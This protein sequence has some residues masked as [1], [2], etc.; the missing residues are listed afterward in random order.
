[1]A[2]NTSLPWVPMTGA[3]H[4]STACSSS[5]PQVITID[6]GS[7][8][9]GRP[10]SSSRYDDRRAVPDRW[11]LNS[12]RSPSGAPMHH[13]GGVTPPP[14][15][16]MR[17]GS[18]SSSSS[19][20]PSHLSPGLP[21]MHKVDPGPPPPLT[22]LQAGVNRHPAPNSGALGVGGVS[23]KPYDFARRNAVSPRSS[24]P[25]AAAPAGAPLGAPVPYPT[26]YSTPPQTSR[27]KVSS[28][29]QVHISKTG[30]PA[31]P[32][33]SPA[34]PPPAHSGGVPR[35]V[36]YPPA[37]HASLSFP[38][39]ASRLQSQPLSAPTLGA[40]SIPSP[41]I[42]D[43]QPLDL[44]SKRKTT[45]DTEEATPAK[46]VKLE[47]NNGAEN[48]LLFKVSEPSVLST[49]EAS[50]ITAVENVAIKKEEPMEAESNNTPYVHKLKKAWIKS[51][52]GNDEKTENSAPSTP[53][54][55]RATPSPALSNASLSSKRVNGHANKDQESESSDSKEGTPAA[56][57]VKTGKGRGGH[58]GRGRG[59][60]HSNRSLR[61]TK[62]SDLSDSDDCSKDSDATT[63]SKRSVK[64][65]G[66]GR[67]GRKPKRGGGPGRGGSK[68]VKED[69]S[70]DAKSSEKTSES[71]G[72]KKG[73]NPFNNPPISVLK[74]T[75]ETFLQDS[76]CF[77]VAPKLTKCRECKWSQHNKNAGSS[78]SIFCR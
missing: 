69:L 67:R 16:G 14:A 2:A 66:G 65:S 71:N 64:S 62:A 28:P 58:S 1:M 37:H 35:A 51:Y 3:K 9:H 26:S 53:S 47:P 41:S 6:D 30:A 5:S 29:P 38:S 31:R 46:S 7:D 34:A 8:R 27:P 54:N 15:H 76:D 49:S 63:S 42:S 59:G 52:T 25:G 78:A 19:S 74:K 13:G 23:F 39:T 12:L 75:G 60:S 17:P 77:K 72:K 44:G 33:S 43:D 24:Y 56:T 22:P 73:E 10:P 20:R 61:Q 70:E 48:G 4:P 32:E 50:N 18:A 55:N 68:A 57:A 36:N 40:S 21:K 11:N 45:E